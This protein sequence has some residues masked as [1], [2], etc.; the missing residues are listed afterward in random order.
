MWESPIYKFKDEIDQ[1]KEYLIDVTG[2]APSFSVP[3]KQLEKTFDLFFAGLNPSET[4]VLDFGAAKLRNSIFLLEKGFSVCACEFKDLFQRTR[5]SNDFLIRAQEFDN[6]KQ[7]IYPDDFLDSEIKF[8]AI[9]LINVLNVMPIPIERLC[10]LHLCRE[11]IVDNGRLL[12]YTQHGAYN[13]ADAVAKLNDGLITGK[14]REYNMFYRDF[15]RNE[16]HSMLEFTG[17]SYDSSK[18]FSSVA[19]GN[20]AYCFIADRKI[21]AD[22]CSGLTEILKRERKTK[23]IERTAWNPISD[24]YQTKIPIRVN[25]PI[26]FD[27]LKEYSKG[28]DKI[29]PGP[30]SAGDYHQLILNILTSVFENQLG[31]PQKETEIHEGRKRID[32]TFKNKAK[33]G[34]FFDLKDRFRLLCPIILIECKNYSED[35]GNPEIDQLYGRLDQRIGVFGIIICRKVENHVKLKEKL[36]DISLRHGKYIIV[37]TDE[38][39]QAIIDFKIDGADTQIDDLLEEKYLQLL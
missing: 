29:S 32:I 27:V 39:I 16:I 17:F 4:T 19:G 35:L 31:K 9:L 28:L 15:S 26:K 6:F 1:T 7:L 30:R 10:A 37:L 36:Y 18:K 38:D 14:G 33:D 2:S 24:T 22:R 11:R 34:F 25:K 5:Q 3:G 12:W 23:P 20:Q 21:L 8:Q 13:E